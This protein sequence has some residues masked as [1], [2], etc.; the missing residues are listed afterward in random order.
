MTNRKEL[1]WGDVFAEVAKPA[2]AMTTAETCAA[3]FGMLRE[4]LT[5]THA[6]LTAA[7][8]F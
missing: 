1:T 8:L 7:D 5:E 6:P 2:P 4:V 3:L